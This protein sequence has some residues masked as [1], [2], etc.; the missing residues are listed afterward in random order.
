[1]DTNESDFPKYKSIGDKSILGLF[2]PIRAI[3]PQI[4]PINDV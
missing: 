4:I 2:I 3:T 1:M